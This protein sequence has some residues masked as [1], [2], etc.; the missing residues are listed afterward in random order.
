MLDNKSIMQDPEFKER[1]VGPKSQE[2]EKKFLVTG[3][4][5]ELFSHNVMHI[6][7][8]YIEV[9]A[10]GSEDRIRES[11]DSIGNVTYTRTQKQGKGLVRGEIEEEIPASQ[12]AELWDQTEGARVTKKRYSIPY[13]GVTIEYDVYSGDLRGLK[14]AEVEFPDEASAASFEPPD[15]FGDEVTKDPNY[16]NQSL[17]T[18]GVPQPQESE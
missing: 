4:D 9:G 18:K 12:F 7:Q 16:K 17:A 15:W 11:R 13:E 6:R 3:F 5:I 14:V 2:I 1:M 8:G 10:D